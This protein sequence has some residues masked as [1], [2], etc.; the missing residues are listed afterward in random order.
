MLA[1]FSDLLESSATGVL[2]LDQTGKLLFANR[3]ARA[4]AQAA[5][6]FSLRRERIEVLGGR[7]DAVLQ[8]LIAG[9]TGRADR[10]DAARGGV[11]RLPRKSGR[12]DFAVVAAPLASGA[13]WTEVG[14]VA[15]VLI[16]DPETASK[17]PEAMIRQLFGLSVAE[18]RVAERLMMGDSPEQAAAILDI[19]T[20]TARW[21]LAS[22]YRKTG[23]SRQAQLVR[24]L[25]SLPMI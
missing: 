3:V 2:L 25:L 16:S 17:R 19:K 7:D 24:L 21:H 15:F 13:S 9:A 12:P 10:V 20:S 1:A 5:D 6:S 14:A 11:M 4:M 8:R 23:T 18:A 22:L